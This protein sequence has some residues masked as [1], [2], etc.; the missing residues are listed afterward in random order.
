VSVNEAAGGGGRPASAD[1][2]AERRAVLTGGPPQPTSRGLN[3]AFVSRQIGHSSPNVTLTVCAHLFDRA[4]HGQRAKDALEAAFG[5]ALET[6]G[7]D[8]RRASDA[9][10]TLHAL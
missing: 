6:S 7:G 1:I 2:K 10:A 8:S 4:E 9:A 5:N 3:V